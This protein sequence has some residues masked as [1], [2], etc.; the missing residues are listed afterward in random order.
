M[1]CNLFVYEKRNNEFKSR[2]GIKLLETGNY[3]LSIYS[4]SNFRETGLNCDD[5]G[6]DI[7]TTFSNNDQQTINFTVE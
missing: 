5:K 2:V 1:G 4:I 6:L 3:K 7:R